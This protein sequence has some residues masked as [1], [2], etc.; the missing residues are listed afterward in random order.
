MSARGKN[1]ALWSVIILIVL[2][3]IL[4]TFIII[5]NNEHQTDSVDYKIN[6]I[7]KLISELPKG[8]QI[9]EAKD[10]YTP[11]K[12]KDY[13]DGTNGKDG[14]NGAD[15][16]NGS[17][18]HSGEQGEKGDNGT[19]AY[20]ELVCNEEKNRWEVRYSIDELFQ[21]LNGTET[22]CSTG[23]ISGRK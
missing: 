13:F 4:N 21:V 3:C 14:I 5:K 1:I 7:T 9:L 12:N 20:I 17:N 6:Q 11:V 15:G 10:G 2:L 8:T 16:Q 23:V 18:G 19:D 22:K